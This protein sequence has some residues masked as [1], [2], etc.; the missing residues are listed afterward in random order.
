MAPAPRQL[1]ELS[2]ME[3]VEIEDCS[4]DDNPDH[5]P[6]RAIERV[7]I[8][9][10][11]QGLPTA[12]V[13]QPE[14]PANRSLAQPPPIRAQSAPLA[15]A[16]PAP[17]RGPA[18]IRASP[19]FE[20]L[21]SL[22]ARPPPANAG[23][24]A[25]RDENTVPA[26]SGGNTSQSSRTGGQST[27]SGAAQRRRAQRRNAANAQNP[28]APPAAP[29]PASAQPGTRPTNPAQPPAP[30][31]SYPWPQATQPA[32]A[33]P[34][35]PWGWQQQSASAQQ[36]W[37]MPG[38]SPGEWGSPFAQSTNRAWPAEGV[39]PIAGGLPP[40][41]ASSTVTPWN[42]AFT[43]PGHAPWLSAG[44]PG[45]GHVGPTQNPTFGPTGP[46]PQGPGAPP[47][48][49]TPWVQPP[50]SGN[51]YPQPAGGGYAA[52]GAPPGYGGATAHAP[53]GEGPWVGP[54]PGV[55]GAHQYG[56][57]Q[58]Q[59]DFY[60]MYHLQFPPALADAP[61]GRSSLSLPSGG[62]HE[63][64]R[65]GPHQTLCGHRRRLPPLLQTVST[66]LFISNLGQSCTR[67]W[68]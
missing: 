50:L 4:D 8:G 6:T 39:N 40:Y 48:G 34:W 29:V 13:G 66:T 61:P 32:Q 15:R 9:T 1:R 11:V 58:T 25:A 18:Q 51:A 23:P 43:G 46:P 19:Y 53:S 24:G 7:P 54:P 3:I 47:G 67:S 35:T 17:V 14:G 38:P 21:R 57:Q 31:P 33:A 20:Y 30:P 55:S 2:P 62:P 16:M 41:P 10:L 65:E 64:H 44:P 22:S 27:T 37:A 45:Y 68:P 12:P 59:H 49:A 56:L 52:G 60:T 28:R 36:H 63:G 26:A 5:P 42:N